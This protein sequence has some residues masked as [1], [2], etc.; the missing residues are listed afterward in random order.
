LSKNA[1][2]LK[3]GTALL[4]VI[5]TRD[6]LY[7]AGSSYAFDKAPPNPKNKHIVVDSDHIS[8]PADA[9]GEIVNWINTFK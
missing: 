4:W 8:T 1:A 3:P 9:A 6:P 7:K 5:G 2:A